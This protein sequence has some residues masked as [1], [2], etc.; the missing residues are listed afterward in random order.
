MHVLTMCGE[1]MFLVLTLKQMMVMPF[2][3]LLPIGLALVKS[4]QSYES[5]HCSCFVC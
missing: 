2:G 5:F 4:L 3:F 1:K